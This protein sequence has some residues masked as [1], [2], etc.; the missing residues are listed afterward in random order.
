[1]ENDN[2]PVFVR[3][4]PVSGTSSQQRERSSDSSAARETSNT[5]KQGEA[6][7]RD[8]TE[9]FSVDSQGPT[10]PAKDQILVVAVQRASMPMTG[11]SGEAHLQSGDSNGRPLIRVEAHDPDAGPNGEI[12]YSIASGNVDDI[13]YLDACSGS[14]FLKSPGLLRRPPLPVKS[15]VINT[16]AEF[17][18]LLRLEAC[19]MGTPKRCA[20]PA[21]LRMVM[22]YPSPAMGGLGFQKV[23]S[24]PQDSGQSYTQSGSNPYVDSNMQPLSGRD[25]SNYPSRTVGQWP[26][27]MERWGQLNSPLKQ[28]EYMKDWRLH[29]RGLSNGKVG[30]FLVDDRHYDSRRSAV[31]AS[32]AVIICLA[33]I[34]AVLLCAAL[35]L[36][37]LVKRRSIYF[38]IAGRQKNKGTEAAPS[39]EY[40][41]SNF[42]NEASTTCEVSVITTLVRIFVG[43]DPSDKASLYRM[44]ADTRAPGKIVFV[45]NNFD[46]QSLPEGATSDEFALS[47]VGEFGDVH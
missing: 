34:F 30:D 4:R 43:L 26:P 6:V 5:P 22:D 42:K 33:V 20:T 28:N 37:Y 29:N 45:D 24:D 25:R 3:P 15:S 38:S 17:S 23:W 1:D 19:D 35:A 36:V 10:P 8:D 39:P 16:E 47:P 46:R 44:V 9:S 31:S 40:V 27:Y 7:V 12:R 32:E 41:S 14:L 18:Y 21:W 2:D 11:D 13:F